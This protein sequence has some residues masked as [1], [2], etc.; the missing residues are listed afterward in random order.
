M[1]LSRVYL[2]A[3]WFSDTVAGALGAG[4][5]LGLA[6]CMALRHRRTPRRRRPDPADALSPSRVGPAAG[7]GAAAC[8]PMGREPTTG[9]GRDGQQ[10]HD[11]EDDEPP[12]GHVQAPGLEDLRARADRGRGR[13]RSSRSGRGSPWAGRPRRTSP[14]PAPPPTAPP[15]AP[16]AESPAAEATP[17]PA[18]AA[19]L[20]AHRPRATPRSDPRPPVPPPP[21]PRPRQATPETFLDEVS[22]SGLAPPVDDAQK[23]GDARDV[24]EE[25]GYGATP[26]TWSARSPSP[27]PRTR[28]PRTSCS[29]RSP[30]ICPEHAPDPTG[31]ATAPSAPRPGSGATRLWLSHT[32]ARMGRRTSRVPPRQRND[33]HRGDSPM[34]QPRPRPRPHEAARRTDG[35]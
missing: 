19:G 14:L 6:A 3:H 22:D 23:L 18:P 26:T 5:A 15:A 28:R 4:L 16:S 32:S 7:A 30:N 13:R 27:G 2:R 34:A 1:A 10:V 21:P 9:A 25:M 17:P 20:P 12:H 29:S 24:C 31:S 33:A 11:H 35:R 8:V